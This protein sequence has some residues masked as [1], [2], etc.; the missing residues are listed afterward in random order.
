MRVQQRTIATP[1]SYAGVGLHTGNHS[2][3]TFRPAPENYGFRFV[4]TD[5]DG[6][7]EIPADV[8][9]VTDISRGTT[10]T[11]NDAS[12]H[13]VE[14]VLAALTGLE[15]DNCRIELTA[16]EPPIGDGSSL[17]YTEALLEAGF[18]DQQAGRSYIAIDESI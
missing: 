8:D 1:V 4:R 6:A 17:P 5:L 15:V 9:L 16:N 18:K 14:H 2:S 11:H 12:V 10:L 3:I 13:T 7:P